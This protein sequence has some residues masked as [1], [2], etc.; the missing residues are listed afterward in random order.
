[1]LSLFAFNWLFLF[2]VGQCTCG[3][4]SWSRWDDAGHWN[5]HEGVAFQLLTCAETLFDKQK[6]ATLE[7]FFIIVSIVFPRNV[8]MG[9]RQKSPRWKQQASLNELWTAGRCQEGGFRRHRASLIAVESAATQWFWV[10]KS[11]EWHSTIFFNI[12]VFIGSCL[13]EKGLNLGG[14]FIKRDV[15]SC[16]C[17]CILVNFLTACLINREVTLIGQLNN[18]LANDNTW[19][20]YIALLC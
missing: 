3:G 8:I 6:A 18:Q 1:M 2:S 10:L 20:N 16:L 15:N 14:L 4:G 5:C 7:S 9:C 17:K 13:G 19:Y 12:Y 11:A